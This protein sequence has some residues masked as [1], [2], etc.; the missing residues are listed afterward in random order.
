MTIN[1]DGLLQEAIGAALQAGIKILEVYDREDFEVSLKSDDSPLTLADRLAHTTITGLLAE[2]G[3]PILSEEG[4][5]IPFMERQGWNRFWLVDPLD[6]TKEFI[7]RNDEFTVNIALIEDGVPVMGVIYAPVPDILY[8]GT[9]HRGSRMMENA[10]NHGSGDI[11]REALKIPRATAN[12]PYRVIASRSHLN[13]ATNSF[14]TNHLKDHPAHEMVS[15]GSS[16]KLC[17][18]AEGSADIYPRFGP[19]MEWD[20]ASGDAIIRAAGGE[21]VHT[22]G[23]GPLQYNKPDLHNPWFIARGVQIKHEK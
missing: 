4:R 8:F 17:M 12:R 13:A 20:T 23:S 7:S 15:R 16:L 5:D 1:D 6:G 3:L 22:D 18:I 21:V 14:I 2:T 10:R 9:M 11:L 19:T